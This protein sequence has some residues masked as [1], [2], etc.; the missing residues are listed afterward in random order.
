METGCSD[1]KTI[2]NI[3]FYELEDTNNVLCFD[4]EEYQIAKTGIN[5]LDDSSLPHGRWIKINS[6]NQFRGVNVGILDSVLEKLKRDRTAPSDLNETIQNIRDSDPTDNKKYMM[7]I[8]NSYRLDG[9]KLFEDISSRVKPALEDFELLLNK[10]KLNDVEKKINNWCGLVGCQAK[11]F[12]KKGLEELIDKYQEFINEV[13]EQKLVELKG[14]NEGELIFE[15]DT[16]K[17]IHPKTQEAACYYGRGTTWCTAATRGYNYFN[18]YNK[19]GPL[20]IIIPKHPTYQGEKYQLH[21]ETNSFMDEEDEGVVIDDIIEKYPSIKKH[22]SKEIEKIKLN[23]QFLNVIQNYDEIDNVVQKID[24]LIDQ[25][26]SIK[27]FLDPID[28]HNDFIVSTYVDIGSVK[29]VNLF[30]D[31][32]DINP[33]LI[34]A[35]GGL[36]DAINL[37]N[38]DYKKTGTLNKSR[39]EYLINIYI[40]LRKKEIEFGLNEYDEGEY[41]YFED[42]EPIMIDGD[43]EALK[44]ILNGGVEIDIDYVDRADYLYDLS[45]DMSDE[46]KEFIK[47]FLK[48]YG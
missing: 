26:A 27:S 37:L 17:V 3:Y 31:D 9:I 22:F 40:L 39:L 25:G 36:E 12:F 4:E 20:Y 30:I 21:F 14:K 2:Q 32:M 1:L 23:K 48:K 8:V 7:W 15:D 34:Y 41:V 6:R 11:R 47:E 10:R 44:M 33:D 16:I 24:D 19:H 43:L 46:K 35:L 18:S 13:R 28:A 29:L 42:F 5:P 38:R 45:D